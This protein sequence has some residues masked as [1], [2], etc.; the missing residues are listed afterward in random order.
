MIDAARIE[1]R[2]LAVEPGLGL[3]ADPGLLFQRPML[4]AIV[5]P[6]KNTRW[7]A[8]GMADEIADQ[9]QADRRQG[10]AAKI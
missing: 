7:P 4:G 3:G 6:G 5:F 9:Q 1:Q 8:D 10:G 2:H